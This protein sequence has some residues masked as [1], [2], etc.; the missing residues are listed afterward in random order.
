MQGVDIDL[1]AEWVYDPAGGHFAIN[2]PARM[3]RRTPSRISRSLPVTSGPFCGAG[4]KVVIRRATEKPIRKGA[5]VVGGDT[6]QC[7][8]G[9]IATTMSI[10]RIAV[11]FV[12]WLDE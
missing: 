6:E 7:C 11:D 10:D 12:Y 5:S 3:L 8:A 4:T 1:V 9:S 2:C